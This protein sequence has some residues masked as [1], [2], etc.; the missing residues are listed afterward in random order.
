ERST[1]HTLWVGERAKDVEVAEHD[2]RE[3]D[4]RERDAGPGRPTE[5]NAAPAARQGDRVTRG[6]GC[7]RELDDKIEVPSQSRHVRRVDD[8]VRHVTDS[9]EAGAPANERDPPRAGRSISLRRVG[10]AP[11]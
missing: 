10:L 4:A 6:I 2:G 9:R 1:G 7:P 5:N 3:I 8:L 11:G